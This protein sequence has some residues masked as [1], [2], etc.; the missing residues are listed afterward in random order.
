[1]KLTLKLDI[2]SKY[3]DDLASTG[4]SSFQLHVGL[5]NSVTRLNLLKRKQYKLSPSFSSSL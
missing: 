4:S 5:S 2:I 3:G 1:M